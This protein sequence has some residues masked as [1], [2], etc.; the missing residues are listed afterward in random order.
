MITEY[1]GNIKGVKL[2]Q[3]Y[4]A[5]TTGVISS[6]NSSLP[7]LFPFSLL[8]FRLNAK[9]SVNISSYVSSLSSLS[10]S[11][12]SFWR[13]RLFQLPLCAN[14]TP[15]HF[16]FFL[17]QFFDSAFSFSQVSFRAASMRASAPQLLQPPRRIDEST[18][19]ECIKFR[20][21]VL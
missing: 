17:S 20:V 2:R 3:I 7:L 6:L 15:L 9:E 13:F 1:K 4:A 21:I 19:E 14:K 18:F 10:A 5:M 8:L 11:S 16:L 12:L